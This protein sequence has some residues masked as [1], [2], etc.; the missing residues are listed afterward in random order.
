MGLGRW[1]L[2]RS[3]GGVKPVAR[4]RIRGP[5]GLIFLNQA[6]AGGRAELLH[7]TILGC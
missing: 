7:Y 4:R 3:A 5:Q 1:E 6:L 2:I